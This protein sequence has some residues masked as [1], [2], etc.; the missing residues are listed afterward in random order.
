MHSDISSRLH[1]LTILSYLEERVK[2]TDILNI[3]PSLIRNEALLNLTM[4]MEVYVHCSVAE[5]SPSHD[6]FSALWCIED[7]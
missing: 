1:I 5:N 3:L 7:K 6:I 4:R 2:T